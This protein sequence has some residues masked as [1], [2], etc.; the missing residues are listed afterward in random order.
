MRYLLILLLPIFLTG[1]ASAQS[2]TS[3]NKK[4]IKLYTEARTLMGARSF[5]KA[6]DK[7]QLAIN[8]DPNFAE[9]YLK[10]ATIY[11]IRFQDSLQMTCYK[12]VVT[13]YP[14][15][16]RFGSAWYYL[17]LHTFEEGQYE[18]A[19]SY[20]KNYQ[21]LTSS[22][23][24]YKGKAKLMIENCA[25]AIAY[26]VNDF[27]FN[28]RP[29]PSNVNQFKQ[30][31]F[32]VLTADQKSLIY[33]KR[34]ANEEIMLSTMDRDGDWE[35][36]VSISENINTE[37]NEG[38]CTISA[39][40]RKLVF[41][42]CMGR[43]G[44]GSCDLYVS[45]KVGE[46]WSMPENMGSAINSSAWDSQPSL[47]ADGRILYFVSNRSGGYGRRDIYVSTLNENNEWGN[48][49]NIGTDINTPFDDISPFIHSNGQRLYFATDGRLGFGGYD[50]YFSE[51]E[52]EG[53]ANPINFGYP[54]NTHNDEVS[55]YISSDGSKGYYSHEEK[56]GDSFS[57]TLFEIDIP[58]KLQ[59][60]H[61]STYVFGKVMDKRT[62][63]PLVATI[64]LIDLE[65]ETDIEIVSSDSLNGEYLIVLTEGKEYGLFA[66]S[67]GYLYKSINFNL[68]E[69]L[70]EPV[71]VNLELE[72]IKVGSK[73]VLNNIF[74][75]FNSYELTSTSKAELSKIIDLLGGD[76][77]AKVQI[78]GF[79]D[80]VGSDKYNVE[81]SKQRAK[82]VY[83]YLVENGINKS[84]LTFVGKGATNFIMDNSSES[85]RSQNRR[86]EFEIVE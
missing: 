53:W 39:D 78:A 73:I 5:D 46:E 82:S 68:T 64:S 4:A 8:K 61:K 43:K 55:M 76:M 67:V 85:N 28:P 54:I 9:A 27:Q 81:L 60:A 56:Q 37:F 13:R 6:F 2:Y 34:E 26:K 84:R 21:N 7:L 86:I 59:I 14:T 32:P 18:K 48:P 47:S 52:D 22:K 49:Q 29:L 58:P 51:K 1:L 38:T 11:R 44:Y 65:T 36:P 19:L 80:N 15:T 25:F 3:K 75:E 20:L 31:Y 79:T 24:K 33:V 42:S 72:S 45:T 40:G 10:L 74:F 69:S 12:E 66:E 70:L 35:S 17:G 77:I 41:T 16:A 63:S 62:S 71:E 23:G 50:I 83:N 57:S 30:Q